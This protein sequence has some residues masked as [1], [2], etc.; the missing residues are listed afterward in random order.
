MTKAAAIIAILVTLSLPL[1]ANAQAPDFYL[2]AMGGYGYQHRASYS[3]DRSYA[4]DEEKLSGS[5]LGAYGGAGWGLSALEAGWL[6][7]PRTHAYAVGLAPER[8]GSQDIAGSALFARALLRAP[9]DW[10]LRPYAF[11]GA[12]RIK[13]ENH[14]YGECAACGPNYRPDFRETMTALRPYIGAGAE[15]TLFGPVSARAEF[16]YIPGAAQ[17]EHV[18]KR[19]YLLGSLAVQIRF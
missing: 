16:G 5:F 12:A 14:E 7:L 3:S 10:T 4:E 15:L 17:S 1:T 6:S 9:E 18:A 8:T 2:G 11:A 19:D 13:A